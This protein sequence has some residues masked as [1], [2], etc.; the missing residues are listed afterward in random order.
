MINWI[1]IKEVGCM[2][3]VVGFCFIK[4]VFLKIY[5]IFLFLGL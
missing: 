3:I 1:G 5:F 2:Y 4:V